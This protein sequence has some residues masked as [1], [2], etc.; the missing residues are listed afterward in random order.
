MNAPS[1]ADLTY[2]A[3]LIER[4]LRLMHRAYNAVSSDMVRWIYEDDS[5][6][7]G[8]SGSLNRNL[9]DVIVH[10]GTTGLN[11][12]IFKPYD[13]M[14]LHNS[15]RDDNEEFALNKSRDYITNAINGIQLKGE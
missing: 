12:H 8:L 4:E 13:Y 5:I 9:D 1:K 11:K 14:T 7:V 2:R 15:R 3:Q 10:I 6:K